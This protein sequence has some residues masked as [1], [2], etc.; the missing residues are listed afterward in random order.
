MQISPAQVLQA[1][2][3]N[4]EKFLKVLVSEG[5]SQDLQL[6]SCCKEICV[7]I[8][9]K[10]KT[11]SAAMVIESA[12]ESSVSARDCKFFILFIYIFI[13]V[14]FAIVFILVI[15]ILFPA[16]SICTEPC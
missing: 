7:E 13:F 3:T 6:K 11:G 9:Q 12:K 4:T 14:Y 1:C 8:C 16:Q 15:Y 10:K 2:K 5:K